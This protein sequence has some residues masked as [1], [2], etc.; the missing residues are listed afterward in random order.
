MDNNETKNS[1]IFFF[2]FIKSEGEKKIPTLKYSSFVFKLIIFKKK[3]FF[4]DE[5][6][7]DT[8]HHTD[9]FQY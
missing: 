9:L 3:E 7:D 6:I 1:Q 2:C 4:F 8:N 5:N